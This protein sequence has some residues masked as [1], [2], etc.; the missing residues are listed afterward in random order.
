MTLEL[1]KLSRS[2]G[3]FRLESIM[4]RVE[5]GEYWA[6]LGPSGAGKS[7]LLETLVGA[8]A[9]ESGGV[10]LDGV[11]ITHTPP[12]ARNFGLVFQT[13]ALFPHYGVEENIEYGL[14]ARRVPPPERRRRVAAIVERVGVTHLLDR[15]VAAL[16]GGE[17]QRVAIARA[18]VFEPR[19]LL[20][21]EPLSLLDHNLR[22]DLQRELGRLHAELGL[23]VLHVTH[24]RE[25][26]RA[27]STHCA[28]MLRGAIVQSGPT[29]AVFDQPIDDEV[30]RFLGR[31]PKS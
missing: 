6:L 28:I 22:I 10:W 11:E 27:L 31:D 13:P 30:A 23:T 29:D 14:T 19:I 4:L 8:Y 2:F 1:K 17:A 3:D 9:A 5:P 24:S 26:A 21:D 18:L 20:L 25:E 16:S 7:L 15:P 12:E